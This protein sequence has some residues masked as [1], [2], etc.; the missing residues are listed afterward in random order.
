[1]NSTSCRRLLRGRNVS[2]IASISHIGRVLLWT[3]CFVGRV[4]SG[5]R[6]VN[7]ICCP[8]GK[9]LLRKSNGENPEPSRNLH[10][11]SRPGQAQSAMKRKRKPVRRPSTPTLPMRPK[12]NNEQGR[13]HQQSFP[14]CCHAIREQSLYTASADANTAV[15]ADR[16]RGTGAFTLGRRGY[17]F[18]N[19][20]GFCGFCRKPREGRTL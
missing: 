14:T 12:A 3:R 16:A 19:Q 7:M 11:S 20:G 17:T 1:M 2:A 9:E 15:L 4:A 6:A 8:P 5:L 10:S 18:I 13:D